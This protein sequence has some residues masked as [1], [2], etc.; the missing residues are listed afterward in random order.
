MHVKERVPSLAVKQHHTTLQRT[1]SRAATPCH[2]CSVPRL[3]TPQRTASH[4]T[5]VGIVPQPLFPATSA[6]HTHHYAVD[7]SVRVHDCPI[8]RC[9]LRH[10]RIMT[11]AGTE[12]MSGSGAPCWHV[13]PNSGRLRCR[14]A[15]ITMATSLAALPFCY[16]HGHGHGH[17][18]DATRNQA[19]P[20]RRMGA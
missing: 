20:R 12:P 19:S 10:S 1:T 16:G 7:I 13:H 2:I 4:H 14:A 15:A 11:T 9:T 18:S 6:R 5:A 8:L 3:T 17:S